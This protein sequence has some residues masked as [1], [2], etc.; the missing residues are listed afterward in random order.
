MAMRL[1]SPSLTQG[2]VRHQPDTEREVVVA[3]S[4][5]LPIKMSASSL[6]AGMI[7]Q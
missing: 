1:F 4:T 3:T 6:L 2:V 7:A 5:G